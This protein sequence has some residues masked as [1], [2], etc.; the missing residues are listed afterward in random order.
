M[1][2][3]LTQRLPKDTTIAVAQDLTARLESL[4]NVRLSWW[5]HWAQLADMFL[6]R[7]Y[8]W[9]ITPNRANKGSQ[10]NASIVD[11]TGVLAARTLATG[12]L[13][14]LTSPTKPWFRLSLAGFTKIGPGPIAD[15]LAEC[16]RRM[17]RVYQDSNFYQAIGVGYHDLAVFGSAAIIQYEDAEDVIRFYNPALGEF[18]FSVN[19]RLDVATLAREYTYTVAQCVEEFGLD[20]VSPGVAQMYKS[21]QKDTEIVIGHIIEPNG[22][23]YCA[24]KNY[25]Q[26]VPPKFEYREVYWEV[27]KASQGLLRVAGFNEKPFVGARWDVTSND[28]YGRSPGMDAL[29]AVRQLQI[30][31]RRKAEAID[32]LVRPPMV[33]SVSMKN[34][35]MDILPGGVTFTSDPSNSG[36][37]PAYTVEPRIQEMMVD[38][39]E[40]QD[41]VKQIMFN[42]LFLMISQLNTVRTATEIDARREEKL[43]LLG[44]VIERFE[45][46]VLD[47]TIERTFSIMARKGMFP[48]APPEIAGAVI[49][50]QYVSMLAEQQRA[51]STAAIERLFGFAGGLVGIV[52]DIFDNLDT[53]IALE[54]YADY[55]KVDPEILRQLQAVM[56]IRQARQQA[57][58]QAQALATTS[59]LASAGKTLSDTNVGGGQNALEAMIT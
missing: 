25:G 46:E 6:P 16:E 2:T 57:Q 24:G 43:I 38:L 31:Q 27:G 49:D 8:R 7:R 35:P 50:I 20:A 33:A 11:E 56:Q 14:D 47:P 30:E 45:N 12:L 17:M 10:L 41:R 42:D 51:A 3:Y 55:M 37:K 15:W 32:K 1:S 39:K 13:A 34:E 44:P 5:S 19:A 26:I 59:A 40:V 9:F 52:P 29:P 23:V 21:N 22:D 28:P 53:D 58:Q 4:R 54:R 48:E 36:F 18:F